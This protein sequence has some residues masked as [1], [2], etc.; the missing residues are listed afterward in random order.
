MLRLGDVKAGLCWWGG[1]GD[2]RSR[3]HYHRAFLSLAG[4]GFGTGGDRQPV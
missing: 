4:P 3:S 2:W 1:G